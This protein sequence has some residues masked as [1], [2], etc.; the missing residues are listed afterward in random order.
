MRIAFL[1]LGI[2]GSRMAANLAR[3]GFE[4][5][6]WNRTPATAEAFGVEHGVA[7][8]PTPFEAAQAAE[9]VITMVLDGAQVQSVLLDPHTGAAAGAWPGTL[10][11]DCST[12]GPS[13]SARIAAALGARDREL[14]LIDAPVAGSSPAAKAGTLTFMVGASPRELERVRPVLDAMGNAIVH[15]GPPGSGQMIK[16]INNAVAA[17]NAAVVGQALLVGARTGLDLDALVAIMRTGSG[18]SA[19]LELKADP[20]RTHDYSTLFKLDHMLKDVR[21]CVEEAG[22]A[23]I[24]FSFAET[25]AAILT[26]GSA[27]GYGQSDMVALIEVLEAAAGARL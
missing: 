15:A 16:L 14:H 8:A 12:I 18:A 27:L 3:S 2:M 5:T 23:G 21:L 19:M 11:V 13:A 17:C 9:I 25:A 7:V 4:L 20:M 6:V 24:S 22:A 1:G 26:E 10:F